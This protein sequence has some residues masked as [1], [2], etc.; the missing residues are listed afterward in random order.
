MLVLFVFGN[1]PSELALAKSY[2]IPY[3]SFSFTN[4]DLNQKTTMS[5][6][7]IIAT[8]FSLRNEYDTN[9]NAIPNLDK[10]LY[11]LYQELKSYDFETYKKHLEV[12]IEKNLNEWWINPEKG[13]IRDEELFA[14]LFEF[15]GYFLMEGVDAAAYGIGTWKD[16]KVQT[17]EFDMGYDY[18]FATKFDALPGITM[19]FMDSLAILDDEKLPSEYKDVDID[20]LDGL[21]ELFEL[22]KFEGFIAIHETLMKMDFEQKF[23]GLNYKNNFM[24]IIDE[25][26]SGE[27]YPLLIKNK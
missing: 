22:Y 10:L 4:L 2:G 11:R 23:E 8:L 27:V 20:E 7:K 15:D 14:I 3:S 12:E 18:D 19:S 16:Y 26:D 6:S 9:F 17:E 13:I 24:F 21:I 5:N 25:H 1:E